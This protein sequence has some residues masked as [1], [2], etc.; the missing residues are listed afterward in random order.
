MSYG[1][2]PREETRVPQPPYLRIWVRWERDECW[3]DQPREFHGWSLEQFV[4]LGNEISV[5]AIRRPVTSDGKEM[6]R[7]DSSDRY[8]PVSPDLSSHPQPARTA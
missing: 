7:S 8:P 2:I 6:L 1:G 4:T 3:P 5:D